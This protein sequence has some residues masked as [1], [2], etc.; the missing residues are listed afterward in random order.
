MT[1]LKK[2]WT[3]GEQSMLVKNARD[4]PMVR[5]T[6][7][8]DPDDSSRKRLRMEPATVGDMPDV[9]AVEITFSA[10]GDV[11]DTYYQDMRL[12][13]WQ[14]G[15]ELPPLRERQE[16]SEEI[17]RTLPPGL[18]EKQLGERERDTETEPP[19]TV[20]VPPVQPAPVMQTPPPVAATRPV[21][22]QRAK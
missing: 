13:P 5:L 20:P 19:E 11:V 2:P 17:D 16:P 3:I 12:K 10:G 1:T 9:Q 8:S 7:S 18:V 21:P 15:V 6:F 14:R 4:E 22:A